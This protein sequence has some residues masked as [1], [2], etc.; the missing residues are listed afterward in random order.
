MR[1][2]FKFDDKVGFVS[3]DEKYTIKI[4]NSIVNNNEYHSP[5]ELLLMAIGS[6]TSD[7]V[8]NILIKMKKNIKSYRCE[9]EGEKR[10][11]HP[12]F[13]KYAKIHYIFEGD[14]SENDLKK[15][16]ELSLTKYCSISLTVKNSGIPVSYDY[17]LNGKTYN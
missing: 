8:L 15:A 2:S 3:D 17:T 11:E 12:R 6:C 5:T 10:D 9:I 16:I 14:M 4:K 1:V 13:L 7:D